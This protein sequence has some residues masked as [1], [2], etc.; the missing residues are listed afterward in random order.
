MDNNYKESVFKDSD[1]DGLS[2]AKEYYYGTDPMDRDSDDDGVSDG[3]EIFWNGDTDGD[4]KINSMDPDSDNDGLTDGT[5]LGVTT[6]IPGTSTIGGTNVSAYMDDGGCLRKNFTAD[7]DPTT[8]TNV[9][10]CDT[11]GVGFYDGW[12]DDGDGVYEEGY[13]EYLGE[14]LNYD[15]NRDSSEMDPTDRDTDEV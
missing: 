5:E 12:V 15:G 2:N 8:T 9:T 13:G 10:L 14:D 7:A 3:A 11:D 6:P 4:G 1:G